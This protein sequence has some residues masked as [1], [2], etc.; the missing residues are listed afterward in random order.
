MKKVHLILALLLFR[1]ASYGQ[2]TINGSA[3]T[4]YSVLP[5][6]TYTMTVETP[7]SA[8]AGTIWNTETQLDFNLPFTLDFE[9]SFS[10]FIN[11][12]DG[13]C[14]V[15]KEDPDVYAWGA[16]WGGRIGY[17]GN[18]VA[19][20]HS[21]A[22]EFDNYSNSGTY[23]IAD[24]HIMLA[25]N[26]GDAP[27][28]TP[29]G[30]SPFEAVAKILP[31]G[32]SVKD[33]VFR[34]YRI[35]WSPPETIQVFVNGVL[36]LQ[37]NICPSEVFTSH[38]AASTVT[39][40][41]TSSTGARVS[42]QYIRN[43]SLT[44]T[45]G[46]L[47]V[48]GI[49]PL[50]SMTPGGSWSTTGSIV[51]ID[52]VAGTIK[53]N[54]IG[55]QNITYTVPGSTCSS[56]VKVVVTGTPSL[57]P[58]VGCTS[59]PVAAT[60]SV[61]GGTWSTSA[62]TV[63]V[64]IDPTYGTITGSAV[65]T[66]NITYTLPGGCFATTTVTMVDGPGIATVPPICLGSTITASA[67]PAGGAWST[68]S[69]NI[70]IDAASGA[71]NA[72]GIGLATVTYT[73]PGG[74][75]AIATA[76][77]NDTPYVY[78]TYVCVG[79]TMLAMATLPGGSWSTTSSLLSIHP[80][81]GVI[82]AGSTPGTATITYTMPTTCSNTKTVEIDEMPK[83][84]IQCSRGICAGSTVTLGANPG[85]GS[86]YATFSSSSPGVSIATLS[87]VTAAVTCTVPGMVT[88]TYT[89]T[90]PGGCEASAY[91][92]F[93]VFDNP[94]PIIGAP[95]V[96]QGSTTTLTDPIAGGTWTSSN[97][98][99]ATID[100]MTGV[101]TGVAPG[102]TTITYTIGLCSVTRDI[103]VV[104]VPVASLYC[105]GSICAGPGS[106]TLTF[107]GTPG[108]VVTY[109]TIPVGSGGGS[110]IVPATVVLTPVPTA[111]TSYV[112]T[113]IVDPATG[114][115][116]ILPPQ[117]QPC[118]IAV[119]PVRPDCPLPS[120]V[121]RNAAGTYIRFNAPVGGQLHGTFFGGGGPA[122]IPVGVLYPVPA[123]AN[124]FNI[125]VLQI[126]DC[127]FQNYSCI[128]YLDVMDI[129]FRMAGSSSSQDVS[130]DLSDVK[131]NIA[132]L[133]ITPNPN[134]GTFKL[135]GYLQDLTNLKEVTVE[136]DDMLG[137]TLMTSTVPV[138][139]GNIE[140][141]IAMREVANG[142]YMVKIKGDHVN[143]VLR[144]VI[145]K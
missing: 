143:H 41:F 134:A 39:W 4:T 135:S 137:K 123:G 77:V 48:G 56:I 20:D 44:Q 97:P 71:I 81:T 87:L 83:P 65:G 76:I 31:G 33:G 99:V 91:C 114:C 66:A 102:I 112:I 119:V 88:I 136:V 3:T 42:D 12:A 105:S 117:P 62:G 144:C 84:F 73:L 69:P 124:A 67:S 13:I 89:V 110:A 108:A 131:Q 54:S 120:D 18:T 90:T 17:Y 27:I 113:D 74:C 16:D 138:K 92:T 100:L 38:T 109:G 106:P 2:F 58:I 52:P 14:A 45:T 128:Y 133:S 59:N 104:P 93:M 9:A 72:T 98:A 127:I 40:G 35:R 75:N 8:Q 15:F 25:K 23:D 121:V 139:D 130:V 141:N 11:G 28:G 43:I 116:G 30:P 101:V 132:S 36:T 61:S 78:P 96:C 107:T 111:T 49:I 118:T 145:D 26:A 129:G 22:V 122:T 10:N 95:T 85:A 5:P 6:H 64:S 37:K 140:E 34:N 53:G 21:L 82:T 68:S 1:F 57:T 32:G 60:A 19:Y 94:K 51:T 70:T 142:V 24:D 103:K 47:C 86:F 50:Y 7:T 55:T 125:Q 115:H 79:G 46:T 80:S 126:G 29:V 63:A